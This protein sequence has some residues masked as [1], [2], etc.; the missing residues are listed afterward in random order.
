M[1]RIGVRR[2]A[3]KSE[4]WET[5][6]HEVCGRLGMELSRWLGV[7][8]DTELFV[9]DSDG[10]DG[11]AVDLSPA[12]PDGVRAAVSF[13]P[14]GA[15]AS[16]HGMF[17]DV[18][19]LEL[20]D[21]HARYVALVEAA[22][23]RI[24]KGFGAYRAQVVLDEDLDLDDFD[25]ICELSEC[26]GRDVDGRDGVYRI[27]PANY[28]DRELCRRAFGLAP[29]VMREKLAPH[30]QSVHLVAGGVYFVV[31]DARLPEQELR[32]VDRSVREL[33]DAPTPRPLD[34]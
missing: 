3:L 31:S 8:I 34:P 9:R 10:G 29:G 12:L 18:F 1:I 14:R 5:L 26:P 30:V 20:G 28:F 15:I 21:D 23:P 32:D 4:S 19:T 2:R 7:A 25:Q 22:L 27:S 33:L 24:V 6:A 17:D 16:D 13:C 11:G